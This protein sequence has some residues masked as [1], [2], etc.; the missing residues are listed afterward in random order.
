M[1]QLVSYQ[2]SGGIAVLDG[3]CHPFNSAKMSFSSIGSSFRAVP[4]FSF[5]VMVVA[6]ELGHLFGSHHTHA[7]VWNGNNS[8]IDGCAGF[9][10]GG[11]RNP[12]LPSQGGT[13]MSYC[14]LQRT[15]INLSLGFG[16]QPGNVIR[17]NVAAASC[18]QVCNTQPPGD[19]P[20]PDPD[21]DPEPSDDSPC[22][23][24]AVELRLVFG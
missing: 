9:T 2:A 18:L 1:A 19:N 13:I 8:A 6:H 4:D 10:E 12:G 17:N 16:L 24:N 22:D 11:C 15:G 7:C 23:G 14:H 20:N 3:L 5:T 21:P